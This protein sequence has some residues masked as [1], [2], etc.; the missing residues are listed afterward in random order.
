MPDFNQIVAKY[1]MPNQLFVGQVEAII[2]LLTEQ[3]AQQCSHV[4]AVTK[5]NHLVAKYYLMVNAEV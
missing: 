4:E 2:D 3:L 5:A 1:Y